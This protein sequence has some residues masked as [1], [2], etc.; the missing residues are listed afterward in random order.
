MARQSYKGFDLPDGAAVP[1]VPADLRTLVDGIDTN[2]MRPR[3]IIAGAVATTASPAINSVLP[4]TTV[5]AGAAAWLAANTVTLPAGAAGLYLINTE[6]LFRSDN[7]VG[8][9]W[10]VANGAGVAYAP[11]MVF[12]VAHTV[13]TVTARYQSSWVR[14]CA[15]GDTFQVRTRGNAMAAPGF[16]QVVRLSVVRLGTALAVA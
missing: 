16:M 15:D 14:Q 4:I 7:V 13:S 12:T 2:V 11:S 6:V 10:E 8:I 5:H 9:N 1:D 3:G